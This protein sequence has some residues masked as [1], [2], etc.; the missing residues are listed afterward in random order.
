MPFNTNTPISPKVLRRHQLLASVAKGYLTIKQV[1]KELSISNRHAKRLW[2]AYRQACGDLSCVLPKSRQRQSVVLT[3]ALRARIHKLAKAH[4]GWSYQHLTDELNLSGE[5]ISRES[6]RKMALELRRSRRR[7]PNRSK[8]STRF[9]AKIFGQIVQMDTCQGAWLKGSHYQYLIA[10]LDDHSRYV[11]SASIYSTDSTWTNLC[12]I[13]H[14][15]E[16]WGCPEI[17]YTDNASHFKTIRHQDVHPWQNPDKYRTRIQEVLASLGIT[18]VAHHPFNPRAKGKIE[19]FF[20][21]IQGR[22]L[23]ANQARN[24]A[25]LNFELHQWLKWY[26]S[27][28]VNGTTK[29]AP[30]T[31]LEP[32]VFKPVPEHLNL[33]ELFVVKETRVVRNDNS[34]SFRGKRYFIPLKHHV[35]GLKVEVH[36]RNGI[37]ALYWRG[38]FL[39]KFT[40]N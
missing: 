13:R 2:R 38:K 26:N 40:T 34:I 3:P 24:L 36:I 14:L 16:T 4:P 37:I 21:F 15:V 39:A 17:L 32:S 8:P 31:R 7:K 35:A 9:E 1:A 6:V 22:L 18:H 20:R 10:C 12:V 29:R 5:T 27:K 33:D 25:E 30:A 28:H 11:V 23:R 19:R